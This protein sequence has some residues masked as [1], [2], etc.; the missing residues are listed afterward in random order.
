MCGISHTC[1]FIVLSTHPDMVCGFL[2]GLS[3]DSV[4]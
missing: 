2:D 4:K 1:V 3:L